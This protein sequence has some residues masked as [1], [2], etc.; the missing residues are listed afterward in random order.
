[1]P[2][3]YLEYLFIAG[4]FLDQL[5]TDCHGLPFACMQQNHHEAGEPSR[6]RTMYPNAKSLP[7]SGPMPNSLIRQHTIMMAKKGGYNPS[8]MSRVVE[9]S[10]T[11]RVLGYVNNGEYTTHIQQIH[12][13]NSQRN[14]MTGETNKAGLY[15][16][17]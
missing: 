7:Q 4:L 16:S 5:M 3:S 11:G 10:N 13:W 6:Q 17:V 14:Q 2:C 8:D 15:I 1:M 12:G 9:Q